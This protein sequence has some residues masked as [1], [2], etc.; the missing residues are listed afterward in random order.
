M[1]LIAGTMRVAPENLPQVREALRALTLA[2]RA[3]AGCHIYAYSEDLLE[4]GLLHLNERWENQALLDEHLKSAH[5]AAWRREAARLGV[6]D[7][8]LVLYEVDAGKALS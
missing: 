4:P 6:G 7:R 1:I 2:T 5:V 3:E 8:R